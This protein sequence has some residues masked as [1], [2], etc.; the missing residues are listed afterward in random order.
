VGRSP[1]SGYAGIEKEGRAC[2][3]KLRFDRERK[4]KKKGTYG[5]KVE[6]IERGNKG[7]DRSL[8]VAGNEKAKGE[9]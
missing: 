8:V 3:T 5:R 4:K 1:G 2:W 9:V 6:K 7:W